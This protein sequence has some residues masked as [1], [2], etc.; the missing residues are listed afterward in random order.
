MD[1][2]QQSISGKLLQALGE[3]NRGDWFECHETLEDLWIGSQGEIRDFY[4]GA[5]QLAVA[6][7][8]WRNGN[9]GGAVSLL[10]GGAGYLRRV[11]PVCQRVDVAGLVSAAD[12]LR[13]ELNRLGPERMAEADRSLFPRMV[14]VA[15]P[16]G[17]EQVVA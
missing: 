7:H 4:Q 9:F 6:L 5:L 8:H 17:E 13:D 12:R 15:V 14:L 3:F 2:C 10:K 11:R 16:A 1:Q